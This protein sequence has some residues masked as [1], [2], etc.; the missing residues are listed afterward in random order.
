MRVNE[1]ISRCRT[2]QQAC[3]HYESEVI[4]GTVY[5]LINTEEYKNF[6]IGDMLVT[7]IGTTEYKGYNILYV[8]GVEA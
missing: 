8:R 4:V 3:I 5:E 7:T 2:D 6:K 1:I